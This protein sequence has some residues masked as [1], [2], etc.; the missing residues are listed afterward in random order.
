LA[1]LFGALHFGRITEFFAAVIL[2]LPLVAI[3]I[4]FNLHDLFHWTHAEAVAEDKILA[5]KSL[6]LMKLFL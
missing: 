4:Y 5:G 6:T 3:P 2:V 1:A